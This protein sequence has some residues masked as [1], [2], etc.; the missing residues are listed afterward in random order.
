M[1]GRLGGVLSLAAVLV[2]ALAH[3]G[4]AP[5]WIDALLEGIVP[6]ARVGIPHCEDM[7]DAQHRLSARRDTIAAIVSAGR[8][9]RG[10]CERLVD[11]A[12]GRSCLDG[13]VPLRKKLAQQRAIEQALMDTVQ[14][15]A[16]RCSPVAFAAWR[17]WRALQQAPDTSLTDSVNTH[18][19]FDRLVEIEFASVWQQERIERSRA[20]TTGQKPSQSAAATAFRERLRRYMGRRGAQNPSAQSFFLLAVLDHREGDDDQ[21]LFRLRRIPARDTSTAWKAPVALLYGQILAQSSPDSAVPLLE[22]A[23]SDPKLAAT[24][25]FLLA[26]LE[27]RRNRPEMALTH[28]ATYLALPRAPAPGSRD[29]AIKATARSLVA[30]A[31]PPYRIR[32]ILDAHLPAAAR[33]TIGLAV[34]R[35]LLAVN[36]PKPCIELLSSFQVTFPDTRLGEEARMLLSQVRRNRPGLV[37]R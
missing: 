30:L 22:T 23:L 7:V 16:S 26:E 15:H 18:P 29:L 20:A 12:A 10:R 11:T 8:A 25:R 2:P 9:E 17:E 21:A 32:E 27:E 36:A 37:V 3:A 19:P 5:D 4:Q 13:L 33:D 1:A 28:L 6:R 14:I 24:A 31:D 34:A 35:Q